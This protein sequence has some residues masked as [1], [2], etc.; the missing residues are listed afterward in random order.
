MTT[1]RAAPTAVAHVAIAVATYRR[2]DGLRRLL[3]SLD[4]L[5]LP[6]MP[7]RITLIVVDNDAASALT[8]AA[9]TSRWPLHYRLEPSKGLAFV[10]NACLDAVPPDADWL[11]FLDDDEWVEPDWLV[12]LL[13]V[14]ARTNA[15]IVQGVVRP[16]YPVPPPGWMREGGYHEVGPFE[17]GAP[18]G[19]G[20]SGNIL[21]R[22]EALAKSGAR[23]HADFNA[24]GGEDVDFF[25]QMLAAGYRLVAANRAVAWETVPS[26]RM[27]LRWVLARRYRTG[28][29]LGLVAARRGGAVQRAVRATARLGLGVT[30]AAAGL[31]TSRTRAVRGL[32][33]VV[34]G[35]GT[36][37]A[38]VTRQ[39]FRSG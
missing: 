38:L 17:D 24:S 18:L 25:Q 15:D 5:Q 23:F 36:L 2:P 10:R 37:V 29:T 11:A 31:V 7:P 4:A 8:A 28:H 30:R 16:V 21:I 1:G 34:W 20:A 26:A 6:P 22:V 12:Q 14:Q 39:P 27:S 3:A 35:V 19:H 33:D 9:L 32:T 13:A